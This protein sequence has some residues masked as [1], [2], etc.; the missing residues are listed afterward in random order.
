MDNFRGWRRVVLMREN[1]IQ[2]K[3]KRFAIRVIRLYQ[4][5]SQEKREFVLSKQLLR[6][7]QALAPM[8]GKLYRVSVGVTFAIK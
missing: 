7:G 4:H 8:C 6:S 5:L 2:E 1:V 3:S